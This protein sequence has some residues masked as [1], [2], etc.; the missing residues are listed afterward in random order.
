MLYSLGMTEQIPPREP[1][2]NIPPLTLV[3]AVALF[4]IFIVTNFSPAQSENFISHSVFIPGV[5]RFGTAYTLLSYALLHFGWPHIVM[6][7]FGLLAFGSAIE[8]LAG[9][10]IYALIFIGGIV[11]GAL[12]HW[13][14]FPN[15]LSPLAGASAGVSALFGAA[16]PFLV[17]RPQLLSTNLVFILS[18][19]ALGYMGMPNGDP[20]Q[21]QDMTIAWQAH[22]FGFAFGEAVGFLI[23]NKKLSRSKRDIT[24]SKQQ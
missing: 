15:S 6:N 20:T 4:A 16:L 1:L 2:L 17:K 14:L 5:L 21:S 13:A 24:S 9:K 10:K 18:N 22:L 7:G 8:R 19:I 3:M 11:L 23:L 12:G